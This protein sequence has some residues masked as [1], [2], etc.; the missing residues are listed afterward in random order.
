MQLGSL[1]L[2]RLPSAHP[3]I[4]FAARAAAILIA[5][6]VAG[7]GVAISGMNPFELGGRVISASFG[8]SFGIED[9]CVLVIPLILTGL[10]V[11]VGQQIGIW[12]IGAEGQ[13][14]AGA[15]AASAVGLF[16]PGPQWM[17]LILMFGAG[18][19]GG[20]VWILVPTLA[21]A[22]ANVNELITTLLLN[23]VATLLVY[24]V[25][26][27]PW[28]DRS[29]MANSATPPL[30]AEVPSFWGIVHWG[31]PIAI[32]L[33]ILVA[34]ALAYSRWGYEVR[35][36]GSNPSAA[37]Y[38]GIPVRKHLITVMLLS[39]GIA[40][41]AG[42][43]EIAGTVHRLQGG[44]SNSFGYLGIMVAVLARGSPIGVIFSGALMAFILNSGII[45][46]TQGL[47]TSVVLAITGFIL[48][49]TAIGDELSYYRVTRERA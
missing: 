12:N 46:Q 5:L 29:G 42:M 37:R 19:V 6:L 11:A 1:R 26:T 22:Y 8:S 10:A 2:Q 28:R 7:V 44:I 43:L 17:V 14:Y 47:T 4:A 41:L 32:G 48:F 31:F 39:G 33:A 25:S 21:R 40:G 30:S 15:F 18:F 9:L 3:G 23:F 38:V 20:M 27:G 36:V 24:Y 13:F 34:A 49:L 16:V 35:L 45:L